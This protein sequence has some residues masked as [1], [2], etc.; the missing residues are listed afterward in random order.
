MQTLLGLEEGKMEV[1]FR[2]GLS[3]RGTRNDLAHP[4]GLA[5]SWLLWLVVSVLTKG[6]C[7]IEIGRSFEG[8]LCIVFD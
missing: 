2:K 8:V 5:E 6:D 7:G 3:L 1:R 4:Y